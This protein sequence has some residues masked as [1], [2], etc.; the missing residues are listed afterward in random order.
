MTVE[1]ILFYIFGLLALISAAGVVLNFHNTIY[2]Y[3]WET[4][5]DR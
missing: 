3:E 4:K 5:I 2:A 1:Q